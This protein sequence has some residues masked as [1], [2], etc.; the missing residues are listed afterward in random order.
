MNPCCTVA[1]VDV[2]FDKEEYSKK[3]FPE[4][5]YQCNFFFPSEDLINKLEV[6]EPDVIVLKLLYNETADGIEICKSIR[7]STLAHRPLILFFSSHTENYSKAAAINA[8]GDFFFSIP[9]SKT[10]FTAQIAAILK[11][12]KSSI[13]KQSGGGILKNQIS[14]DLERYLVNTAQG[15]V[16]LPKKEFEILSLLMSE[17]RK[18]FTREDIKCSIW[19]KDPD[20]VRNRTIDVHIRKLREKIGD[21]N[22]QTIK[23]VGYKFEN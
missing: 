7:A 15:E 2:N 9:L 12:F 20:L 6:T 13:F 3:Y 8:G 18:V 22:I 10:Y 17:P 1:I 14:I 5:H 4:E 19:D 23:G 11:R 16:S 21:T